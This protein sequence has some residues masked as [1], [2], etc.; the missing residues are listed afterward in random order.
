M[1]A[2]TFT[3]TEPHPVLQLP[4]PEE[5]HAMGAENFIEA[6]RKREAAIRGE[7]HEPLRR[8]WEPPIWRVCDALVG[9]PWVPEA[10]AAAI[11]ENLGFK[12]PVAVLY[13]LG[14]QRSS[15]TEYATNRMSRIAELKPHGLS[16]M[17]HNTMAAS[18][19]SHQ[20][21]IWKY[22]PPNLKGKSILSQT[23]YIAY[24]DK[25]GFSDGSLVRPNLHKTR[26]LSYDMPLTDLQGLNVDA[27]ALDEFCTP[28]HVET[29]KA[30]T[31]VKVGCVFVMLAPILGYTPLVQSASDGAEVCREAVAF[32]CP[33][34]GGPRDLA[35][36][37]GLTED[38][39]EKIK[40]WLGR[41]MKPPFPN[42]P[43]CRPED[44]SQWLIDK[45]TGSGQPAVPAGRAFK[46]VPRIQKPADPEEK[47]AIVHFHG[48]DNPYGN[49][50]S[51]ALLNSA[52]SEEQGK[53]I[54]YGLAT[55]GMAR[56]FPKFDRRI[57]VIP[58]AAI[59]SFGTNY[60][61]ND[62]APGRNPFFTWIRTC[63]GQRAYV[64][65]EW[66]GNYE[67][68]GVGVPGPWALPHG[69]L[70]DG[71]PG[72]GQDSFG[73]GF[74]QLK[75]EFAR[76]EGWK[77][78]Q[79]PLPENQSETEWVRGWSNENGAREIVS[80]RFIDSRAASMPHIEDDR[81]VTLLEDYAKHGLFFELTP[82]DDIN[83][84]VGLLN[85]RLSYDPLKKVDGMNCPRLYIAASC[86]NTIFAL[87]TW[88]NKEGRKGATKD[89]ID[90]LR[91]FV[92]QGVEYMAPEDFAST[93][94]GHY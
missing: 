59:P 58:D 27:G 91:Y 79:Q 1:S 20:K 10:E 25:T 55:Q 53:R 52:A 92:L 39:A 69:K 80:R 14:A 38:E 74:T 6:M 66:P 12:Q 37:A 64:Y 48:G 21:L 87:L 36:Y 62:P 31:A 33:R 81:P 60:V 56:M 72:P 16:W 17:F 50:L 68:P 63:P 7:I 3:P 9:L 24:K 42:V 90:N 65:R 54:F 28:E 88:R 61:W 15:K 70:G 73:F 26:F 83:E 46:T 44:C 86:V 77:D 43:F 32:M 35:R 45:S 89:P 85:D 94:G 76:L 2:G 11:R 5:A 30:R 47:S 40:A 22:L 34:D 41:K 84:G 19:D 51:L 13:L 75:R 23:T 49:P 93:G 18:I 71:A 57:H 4:T 67:I 78:A 29:L 82:G 8:C